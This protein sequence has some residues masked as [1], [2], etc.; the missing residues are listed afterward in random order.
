MT[1]GRYFRISVKTHTGNSFDEACSSL[2]KI[3]DACYSP[4]LIV[5]IARGGDY[6]AKNMISMGYFRE[7]VY[8]SI[9]CQRNSTKSKGKMRL[10]VLLKMLPRVATNFLR[11]VESFF[12]EWMFYSN[13]PSFDRKVAFAEN[14]VQQIRHAKSV[15]I[16][17]DAV[18]SGVTLKTVRDWVIETNPAASIRTAA[19]TTTFES[20]VCCP[21]FSLYRDVL[22]R[23]PWS[24]DAK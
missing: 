11:R 23:F 21:D 12:L 17:D 4:N 8:V 5:G 19:I 1:P 18:D 24:N 7:A 14:D 15:L 2:A 20:P 16:I 22:V 13:G 6:I 3:V 10:D 9:K